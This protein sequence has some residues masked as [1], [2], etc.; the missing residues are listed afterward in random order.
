MHKQVE[1]EGKTLPLASS[2][3]LDEVLKCLISNTPAIERRCHYLLKDKWLIASKDEHNIKR[4]KHDLC[5]HLMNGDIIAKGA[6]TMQEI[7]RHEEYCLLCPENFDKNNEEVIPANIWHPDKISWEEN[8][9]IIKEG[10]NIKWMINGEKLDCFSEIS[11][12]I[13]EAGKIWSY[14]I[15]SPLTVENQTDVASK[16][17]DHEFMQEQTDKT[18]PSNEIDNLQSY[19]AILKDENKSLKEELQSL[20]RRREDSDRETLLKIIIG[21]A[22]DGYGY[23]PKAQRNVA[24]KKIE[25]S[26]E[27]TGIKVTDL[28]TLHN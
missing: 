7:L 21:M 22:M 11:I 24:P 14:L 27:N 3:L 9:L 18:I 1:I 19:I 12:D 2:L 15:Q 6:K 23:K 10:A 17:M 20:Q 13:F 5:Y 8:K 4:A 26:I 16:K 28:T 25:R